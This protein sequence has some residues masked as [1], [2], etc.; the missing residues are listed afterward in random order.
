MLEICL[1]CKKEILQN[2]LFDDVLPVHDRCSKKYFSRCHRKTW[3]YALKEIMKRFEDSHEMYSK[4]KAV[5]YLIKWWICYALRLN[6]D[7]DWRNSEPF[8]YDYRFD[9][10]SWDWDCEIFRVW[11]WLFKNWKIQHWTYYF[12]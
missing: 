3:L 8:F 7:L 11:K 6:W 2:Q 4:T 10:Y 5:M 12:F 1:Q 9:S